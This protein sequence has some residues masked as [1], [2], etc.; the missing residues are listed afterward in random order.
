MCNLFYV[1]FFGVSA[2]TFDLSSWKAK[3]SSYEQYIVEQW[4]KG[5]QGNVGAVVAT[6]DGA[7]ATATAPDATVA[8]DMNTVFEVGSTTKTF[9]TLTAKLLALQNQLSMSDTIAKHLPNDVVLSPAVGAIT[10]EQ[11]ATH[12]SGLPRMPN[13]TKGDGPS[14]MGNYTAEDMYAYLSSL[15]SVGPHRFLYS[16]TGFGLLGWITCLVTGKGWEELVKEMVVLPLALNDTSV[17]LSPS[18]Q[19]RLAPPFSQGQ[20]SAP[21]TFLDSMVGAGGLHSTLNDMLRYTA[22]F[23]GAGA[24]SPNMREAMDSMLQARAPDEFPDLRG[25]VDEAFQQYRARGEKVVWKDG[26]TY[27]YNCMIN[28]GSRGATVVLSNTAAISATTSVY[29][30]ASLMAAGPP[31]QYQPIEVPAPLLKGYEGSFGTPKSAHS[32]PTTF[33]VTV[34]TNPLSSLVIKSAEAAP[35]VVEAFE[36]SG[37]FATQAYLEAYCGV[38][39]GATL[40]MFYSGQDHFA[41]RATAFTNLITS[42]WGGNATASI[43]SK[44]AHAGWL[45]SRSF[46]F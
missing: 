17:K 11:L 14:A 29:L 30:A 10:L 4:A 41:T 28:F 12:T 8:F 42:M 43:A 27:G 34:S 35:V 25:E 15:Q 22:A 38:D 45:Q 20:P 3:D 46:K 23:A 33:E 37:F 19:G 39:N 18:Q 36:D 31:R 7:F 21:T 9:T 13:N 44:A 1:L 40:V 32:G 26:A 6:S 24:V 2:D 5:Q 16:N